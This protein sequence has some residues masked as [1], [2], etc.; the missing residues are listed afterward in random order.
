MKRLVPLAAAASLLGACQSERQPAPLAVDEAWV[1]LAPVA[2][3][4]AA[5]YFTIR[6]GGRESRLVSVT[7]PEAQRVELHESRMEGGMSRMRPLAEVPVPA[8][9][10]LAFAPGGRHAMLFG[11]SS[12]VQPFGQLPLHLRFGTGEALRVQ[13][14]VLGAGAPAPQFVEAEAQPSCEPAMRQEGGNVIIATC[15]R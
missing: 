3:Q 1:R 14:F 10:E 9:G 4:P 7:S 11:L 12:E 2:G 8:G 15:G 5:A 13:A 6:G